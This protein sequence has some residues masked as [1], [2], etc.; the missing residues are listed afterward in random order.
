M[1]KLTAAP[2]EAETHADPLRLDGIQLARL[3]VQVLNRFDLALQC[4][5]CNT[6]WSPALLKDGRLP[7]G[8]WICPN[9]CNV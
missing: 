9:K 1:S 3:G 4:V 5:T 2:R 6:V 7:H 8:Y